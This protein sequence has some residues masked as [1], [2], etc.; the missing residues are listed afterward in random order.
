MFT[1]NLPQSASAYS[2]C[3]SSYS[4]TVQLEES[5]G[6]PLFLLSLLPHLLPLKLNT[7][8]PTFTA[9]DL[10]TCHFTSSILTLPP[11]PYF[12]SRYL[13]KQQP[14]L[15]PAPIS[16]CLYLSTLSTPLSQ[17]QTWP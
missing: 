1:V 8:P 15:S 9:T 10:T 5:G 6:I 13:P 16:L 3:S 2:N 12:C 17:Q 11:P 4:T 14:S 7:P